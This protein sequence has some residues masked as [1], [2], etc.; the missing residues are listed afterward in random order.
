MGVISTAKVI[1]GAE[2]S[3][4]PKSKQPG[5]REWVTAIDCIGASGWAL[6]PVIIFEGKL[7][8]NTWYLESKL[9]RD[10]AI[11]L[12]ENGWTDDRLGLTWL[13]RVFEIYTASCTKGIYRLLIL[14][15][16]S[17]HRTAEFDLFCKEHSI[18]SLCMPPHSS[19]LLQPLD[20]G[21]FAVLKR[22]YGRQ[23]EGYIRNGLNHIDK[24]DFLQ[25]YYTAHIESISLANVQSS[26]AAT[27]IVPYD[28]ERVLSK[29]TQFKTPIPPS[30]SHAT[31]PQSGP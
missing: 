27:G 6:P 28:P 26:F 12:S 7:H 1:T 9:P 24:Q 31:A 5:N 14:D 17:S 15:G 10:W 3:N 23:I 11:G 18:I 29:L 20:V 30:S 8:Q 21:C 19:H 13:E 4:R 16:H 22:S 2:R 25:A